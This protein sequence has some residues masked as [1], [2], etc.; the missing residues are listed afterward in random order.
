[1]SHDTQI[2]M[3]KPIGFPIGWGIGIPSPGYPMG[4]PNPWHHYPVGS[5][6]GITS[7]EN[8]TKWAALACGQTPSLEHESP[9]PA[10]NCSPPTLP[11]PY[12]H[13]A[14]PA[15]VR[16]ARGAVVLCG[17]MSGGLGRKGCTSF[18][19]FTS[20]SSSS[21]PAF[22]RGIRHTHISGFIRIEYSFVFVYDECVVLPDRAGCFTKGHS[23]RS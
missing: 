5:P 13:N 18:C 2:T 20:S 15:Y 7:N 16:R 1:M 11:R 22:L 4:H 19:F 12:V 23:Y 8:H 10:L 21:L 14:Y 9:P 6:V 17:S 3:G